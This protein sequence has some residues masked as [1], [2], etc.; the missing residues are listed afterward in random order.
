MLLTVEDH[1]E[2]GT[3]E[4][5]GN[6]QRLDYLIRVLINL[7]DRQLSPNGSEP[8]VLDHDHFFSPAWGGNDLTIFVPIGVDRRG[9]NGTIV[10]H[11]KVFR[12]PGAWT[13]GN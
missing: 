7:R 6:Y 2:H 13:S 1:P 5:H 11:L 9:A 10:H 4:L 8:E 3:V 12:W